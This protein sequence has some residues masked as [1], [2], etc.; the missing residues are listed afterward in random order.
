MGVGGTEYIAAKTCAEYWELLAQMVA[1]VLAAALALPLPVS[2]RGING[3][4]SL[5]VHAR[6]RRR[7][8]TA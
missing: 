6:A 1:D 3:V 7:L 2:R 4:R 5:T 8:G